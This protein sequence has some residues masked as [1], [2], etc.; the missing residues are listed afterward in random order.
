MG[1]TASLTDRITTILVDVSNVI[2]GP[3]VLIP[4]LL[5]TGVVLTVRL[6]GIQAHKL[7]AALHLGLWRRKDEDAQ[8][9]DVSQF[10]ALTTA[11]AATVG[12]GNI[13][14]V[15]TAIAVGGPGALFWM[16]VTAVFGMASKYTEAFLAV[17]YR[18]TDRAGEKSGGPQY[19]LQRGIKGP[20]GKVLALSFAVFAV[21]ASFGIGNMTQG[22]SIASNVEHSFGVAPWITGVVLTVLTLSVLVG[23][24]KSIGRVT[25]NFVPIMIVFYVLGSA[26]ILVVNAGAIPAALGAV[27]TE[28]FTGSAA[29]GGFLGSTIM[30]AMRM[31]MARGIFSNES[32]MGSAAI[33]AA[34]AQT[35]HPVRQGLVS[36][37]QTFIDTIIVVT[38][39]GLVLLTTGAWTMGRDAAA[40]MT[41]EAFTSGLPG[42]W[43]HWVVTIAL[44]LFAYSTILGWAYYGERCVERLVGRG[45]VMPFR[46][47]FS[48]VVYVG[49][50][51][52]LTLVWNFSDIMN[53]LMAIPNLIGLLVLSG[54]V[55]RETRWYLAHDPKLV[56]D[57]AT[58]DAFMAGRD[59]G[60][61]TYE[62]TG[63]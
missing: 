59:G 44:A 53:G 30:V 63:R 28:A 51:Q 34:S 58:I 43:G 23:G 24:I 22:N 31:G 37:T 50:T 56:A 46:F 48:L 18:T 38:C 4:L 17:R 19:Y 41:G 62:T 8:E 21:V 5:V 15:A 10:Q 61:D 36:M 14:G 20:V 42:Q 25:A 7:G 16:W 13:V 9:G 26:Y 45:G 49:C 12:T 33:A 3:W 55:A 32:G 57:K 39:T 1:A 11:L 35:T 6:R 27:F 60:I 52:T 29:T 54:L 47:V 2:W 40:T